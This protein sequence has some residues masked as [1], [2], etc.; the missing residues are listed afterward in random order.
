MAV[1]ETPDSS[2][3]ISHV[4]W[5]SMGSRSVLRLLLVASLSL[6]L[7]AQPEVFIHNF[8]RV[9]EHV[10]RGAQPG[11]EGIRALAAIGV[12]TVIDLRAANERENKEA[13]E[14]AALGIKYLNVPMNGFH[15]PGDDQVTRVLQTLDDSTA[16]PVFV[17]CKYGEDRTG[18]VIACYRVKHDGWDNRKALAEA[19][20]LGMHVWE[21]GM[22]R[23]ILAFSPP[24]PNTPAPQ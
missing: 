2:H 23:F 21:S 19:K 5:K 1:L 10:L 16:W 22:K 6:A 9:D 12:K 20:Q 3:G 24:V 15:A 8:H 7:R 14:S 18:T 11:V 4:T 13:V 17:H